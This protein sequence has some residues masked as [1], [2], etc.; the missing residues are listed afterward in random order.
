MAKGSCEGCI[1]VDECN[2]LDCSSV[3]PYINIADYKRRQKEW[4]SLR[5]RKAEDEIRN[6]GVKLCNGCK[7][8]GKIT[9]ICKNCT[10]GSAYECKTEYGINELVTKERTGNVK[11]HY[12]I[13]RYLNNLYERKNKDYGDSFHKTFEEW[14]LVMS[15]IRLDDKLGRL[16]RFAKAGKLEVKDE[17][18][19]DTLL[20]LANY[21]IMTVIE[22]GGVD[23]V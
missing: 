23:G 17:S 2:G 14:G 11:A 6:D 15:A 4:N 12:D 21:A 13:C 16:K 5:E 19:K 9:G 10:N 20:D 1:Y 8:I 22:L 3:E 7:H 18:I